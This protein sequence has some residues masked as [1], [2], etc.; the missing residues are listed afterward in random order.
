MTNLLKEICENSEIQLT[1]IIKNLNTASISYKVYDIPKRTNGV[2]TI[3]QPS[4]F[5]KDVQKVITKVFLSEFTPSDASFAYIE[6]K[7]IVDNAA[8]HKD[9]KWI[10]KID[11]KDFFPSIKPE[12]LF[13]FLEKEEIKLSEFDK[14]IISSYLF[15]LNNRK[16]EL[17]IGAPS[18]PV[19]S[20]LVMKELDQE[21]IHFCEEKSI[22]YSRYADDLTFSTNNIAYFSDLLPYIYELLSYTQSP[23]L[24]IND[25]KTKIIGKGRSQRITGVVI[26]HEGNLSV[27]RYCRK[28][29][30]AMLYSYNSNKIKKSDIPYLHGLVSHMRNV[31][32][33]YYEKL[34]KNYGKEFF[35]KL[36]MDSYKIGKAIKL[37]SIKS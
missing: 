7:S 12:D 30:R 21:I 24:S 25:K 8:I 28:K 20:N 17:S 5:V 4:S 36:A 9:N 32:Y 6:G 11:F 1:D 2:R 35:R 14:K 3:A 37:N 13:N 31:E 15:R 33:S 34:E 27:G 18:S 22:A 16:L 10:L 19:I 23:K 26:T 29:I